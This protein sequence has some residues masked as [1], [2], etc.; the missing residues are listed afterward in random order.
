[1]R[2]F[3]ASNRLFLVLINE[4][5]FFQSWQLKRN[6]TLLA[7]KIGKYLDTIP[8]SAGRTVKFSWDGTKYETTADVLV[9]RHS[10]A[11]G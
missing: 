8:A 6:R 7:K 9:V 11:K 1:E 4:D 2:R 5:D 10:P 3:D